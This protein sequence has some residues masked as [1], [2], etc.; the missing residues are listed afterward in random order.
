MKHSRQ[1]FVF[2]PVMILALFSAS[3]GYVI[4]QIQEAYKLSYGAA[5][6]FSSLQSAG[7]I[8][9]IIMCFCVFSGLNKSRIMLIGSLALAVF[10]TLLSLNL[11]LFAM[12]AVFFFIGLSTNLPDTLSH[13]LLADLS[14]NRSPFYISLLHASWAIV[15]VFGPFYAMLISSGYKTVFFIVGII[16]AVCAVVYWLGLRDIISRPM[17][18]DKSKMGSLKKL[19]KIIKLRGMALFFITSLLCCFVQM[20]LM[21]FTRIYTQEVTGSALSGAFALSSLY[22][23]LFIGDVAYAFISHKVKPFKLMIISNSLTLVFLG[24]MLVF[25]NAA[26]ISVFT[27][28]AAAGMAPCL[29]ILISNACGTA[30]HDTA[31]ASAFMFFGIALAALIAPPLIGAI[32]DAA[33]LRIALLANAGVYIIVIVLS[34]FL[35]KLYGSHTVSCRS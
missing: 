23:G 32:G 4:P 35:N 6:L 26:A 25:R 10:I 3:L 2:P 1:F 24:A 33:G 28:L 27:M 5:G 19:I 14:G 31:A 20:P 17:V 13:A 12:Y 15:G 11:A 7:M 16:T 34:V 18:E 9:A 22:F 21:Y 29:P 30:S 8:V